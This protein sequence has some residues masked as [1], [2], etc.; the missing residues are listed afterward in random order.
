MNIDE[1]LKKAIDARDKLAGE[2][3]RILGKQQ[4]A[5]QSLQEVEQEIRDANLDPE[6]LGETLIKLETALQESIQDFEE[7]VQKAKETLTPYMEI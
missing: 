3:Q 5:K 6:T 4:A 2:I 1:R 7:K